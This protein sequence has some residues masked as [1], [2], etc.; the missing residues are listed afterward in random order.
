MRKQLGGVRPAEGATGS[1]V[2]GARGARRAPWR[3]LHLRAARVAA[4]SPTRPCRR[5]PASLQVWKGDVE[6]RNLLL[7][8]EAL[9]GLNLPVTVKAGL[10]GRLT[11]KVRGR[12]RGGRGGEA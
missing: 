7:K 3:G 5:W 4:A 9:A 1:G 10:L 12:R 11:L 2:A 6:L 8:P